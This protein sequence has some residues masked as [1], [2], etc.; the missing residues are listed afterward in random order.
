MCICL[1]RTAVT[2]TAWSYLQLARIFLAD[3]CMGTLF[4]GRE[5]KA[6]RD[7]SGSRPT[8]AMGRHRTRNLTCAKRAQWPQRYSVGTNTPRFLA[9]PSGGAPLASNFLANWILLSV[10]LGLRPPLRSIRGQRRVPVRVRRL[11]WRVFYFKCCFYR[12]HPGERSGVA[13][14]IP[15]TPF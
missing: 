4:I 10:I 14:T 9:T 7:I 2:S 12:L 6:H 15:V 3:H 8:T 5:V 13:S 1:A 11:T